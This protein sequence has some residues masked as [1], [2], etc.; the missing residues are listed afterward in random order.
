MSPAQEAGESVDRS[1][2]KDQIDRILHSATFANKSQLKKLLEI[3]CSKIDSQN[4]LN[5]DV[6]IRELWPDETRTKRPADVASEM[7]R[8]RHALNAY[9]TGEGKDDPCRIALPNRAAS[10][11]NGSDERLWIVVEPRAVNPEAAGLA[12]TDRDKPIPPKAP[13]R[14]SLFVGGVIVA[15]ISLSVVV[16]MALRTFIIPDQPRLGRLV[17]T[18]LVIMNEEGKELWRK[19]FSEGFG[20]DSYYGK[21]NGPRIWFADLEGKGHTSVLFSYLP[22]PD[23]QPHSSML[24]CYSDRGKERWRWKSGTDLPELMGGYGTFWTFS[25]GVLKAEG[26]QPARIVAV[27]NLNPWWG[28]PSQIAVI[29]PGGSTLAEYWHSGGLHDLIITDLEGS[30]KQEIIATGVAHGYGS[31]ATLVV[32][33]PDRLAGA[34][35][36]VKPEYRM[37]GM[38]TAQE[39]LRFLFPRSDLNRASF[40]YNYAAAPTI[41]NGRLSVSVMECLAP[42]G[43]PV[44]YEFDKYFNLIAVYPENEEFRNSHDRLYRTGNDAH[45]LNAD[46]EGALLKVTCL[47]GCVTEF[48]PLV[49][50]LNSASSFESGWAA[51]SNPNG[52]WSY[53]YSSGLSGAISLYDKTAQ[54][55]INGPHTQYWLSSR[56]DFMTS[57]AV[58][59]NN[60]PSNND[61]NVDFLP[62]ELVLVAGVGGQYSDLIFRAPVGGEYSINGNFRGAQFD[63]RTDVGIVINGKTLFESK[64]TSLGQIVPFSIKA[65]LKAGETAVFAAGPAGGSQNTG[66]DARVTELC[67][68]T[69]KTRLTP[70][71]EIHCSMN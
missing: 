33:D 66:L 46:E 32:L 14:K 23:S 37:P 3:L 19:N 11:A 67:A 12:G 40:S 4:T 56:V 62:N 68:P 35:K 45:L 24:I 63:V 61:G 54:N 25:V 1:A 10:V 20:P 15:A 29:D 48:A 58:E 18:S 7:N 36:E 8:L 52:V 17:G 44:H 21:E 69:D 49:Q 41:Q 31:Q 39:R 6:V 71:G 26:N 38:K 27:S 51:K 57:P 43:C 42:I 47:T 65:N 13:A 9:Y 28:G 16:T 64:V 55:G 50:T 22:A 2:I 60:G 30:G 59:Y 5:S 53:G 70:S 34:S